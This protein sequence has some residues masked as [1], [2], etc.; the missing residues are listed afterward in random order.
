MPARRGKR[1]LGKPSTAVTAGAVPADELKASFPRIN[2]PVR[3]PFPPMEA[4]SVSQIPSGSGWLYEPKW[5][6]FRAIAFRKGDQVLLQSKSGQPLGRYFPEL[7]EALRKLPQKT[8]VLDGEIVIVRDGILSFDD[9]LLRIHPAASRVRKLASQTPCTYLAFDIL[10]DGRGKPVTALPLSERRERLRAFFRDLPRQSRVRLSPATT[11][12]AAAERWMRELGAAGF[13]GVVAKRS[14]EPY[15]SGER[16]MEKI[17]RQRTADC[18]VGGF[19][20]SEKSRQVGSLL[21]GLYNERGLLDHVGFTSS[22]N[23]EDRK[24]LKPVVEPLIGGAG[25]SGHAPGGP[26]RWSTRRSDE[27]QPLDPRLVCEVQYDHFSGGRFRHGTK[28]LRWRPDK[29]PR[30]CTFEQVLGSGAR[31]KLPDFLADIA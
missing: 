10:V 26:S 19:R 6:G 21:L 27:W 20:Y 25:F 14:A 8:F 23:R 12:R 7:V 17:K 16:A 4:K 2:L 29:A 9:L 15:L 5:D 24:A 22:F 18:V 28:F 3:P 30:Q 13:D 11:D 1:S 31:R